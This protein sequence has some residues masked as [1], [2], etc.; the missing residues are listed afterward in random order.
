MRWHRRHSVTLGHML[1]PSSVSLGWQKTAGPLR[2]SA[3][4]RV[5]FPATASAHIG[6]TSYGRAWHGVSP[7]V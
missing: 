5:R 4:F 3:R 2:V 7:G 6:V 1:R